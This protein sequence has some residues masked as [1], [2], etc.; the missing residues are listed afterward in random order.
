[1]MAVVGRVANDSWLVTNKA[2]AVTPAQAAE[3]LV[4]FIGKF[5]IGMTGEYW[6]PRGPRRVLSSGLGPLCVDSLFSGTLGQPRR[7]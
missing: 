5:N 1:M 6:A 3:S 4:D 2:T 7:F